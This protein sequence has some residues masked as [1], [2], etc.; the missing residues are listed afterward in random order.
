[1]IF[2]L[3]IGKKNI[4]VGKLDFNYKTNYAGFWG[5]DDR[6]L[7]ELNRARLIFIS[8]DV[9]AMDGV[10]IVGIDKKGNQKYVYREWFLRQKKEADNA[11]KG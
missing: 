4:G 2:D 6:R 1:M 10:E 5:I 11:N 9:M 3:T 7:A 8:A